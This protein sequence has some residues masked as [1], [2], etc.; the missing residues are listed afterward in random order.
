MNRAVCRDQNTNT[1]K[2][3]SCQCHCTLSKTRSST[4]SASRLR[5]HRTPSPVLRCTPHTRSCL[6]RCRIERRY[7]IRLSQK[8]L[9]TDGSRWFPCIDRFQSCPTAFFCTAY[10]SNFR[11][12]AGFHWVATVKKIQP[13]QTLTQPLR[14]AFN[15]PVSTLN[16]AAS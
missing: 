8:R 12:A 14:Q 16:L 2:H 6:P 10:S 15:E 5:T 7:V 4:R 9:P 1:K 13:K 11:C 3:Q